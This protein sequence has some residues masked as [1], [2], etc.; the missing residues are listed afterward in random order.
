MVLA[1]EMKLKDQNVPADART[2]SVGTPWGWGPV[3][4]GRAGPGWAH[5][6]RMLGLGVAIIC[7]ANK[8]AEEAALLPHWGRPW[9]RAARS[10]GTF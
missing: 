4:C 8:S 3:H 10:Q 2:G 9:F 6:D 7:I 1:T 5:P